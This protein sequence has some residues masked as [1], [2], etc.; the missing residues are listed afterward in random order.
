MQCIAI[1]YQASVGEYTVSP[2]ATRPVLV[3]ND[4]VSPLAA[5]RVLVNTLF[6]H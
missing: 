4:T 3:N 5:R 1:G 2:L 6:H